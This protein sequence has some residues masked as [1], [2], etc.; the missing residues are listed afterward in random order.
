MSEYF[1]VPKIVEGSAESENLYFILEC[2]PE[3]TTE[4]IVVLAL[5]W[6]PN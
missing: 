6:S 2:L 3:D 4:Y 1:Y 5:K